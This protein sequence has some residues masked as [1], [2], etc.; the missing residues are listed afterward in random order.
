MITI[1]SDDCRPM[2]GFSTRVLLY[3]MND[4]FQER[5]NSIWHM[6]QSDF[7]AADPFLNPKFG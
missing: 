2:Y 4:F 7:A 6:G 3:K 5:G 1:R